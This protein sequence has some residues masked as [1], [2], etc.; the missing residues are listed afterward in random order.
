MSCAEISGSFPRLQAHKGTSP[1]KTLILDE[2]NIYA[3]GL[4]AILATPK[5]LKELT[6]GENVDNVDPPSVTLGSTMISIT[7]AIEALS[8]TAHSLEKLTHLNRDHRRFVGIADFL[9][10]QRPLLPGPGFKA[11]DALKYVECDK[12][13]F[14]H[15]YITQDP[16]FAPPNLE[17]YRLRSHKYEQEII[18]SMQHPPDFYPFA[19]LQNLKCIEVLKPVRVDSIL[20][21]CNKIWRPD[22]ARSL[23]AWAYKLWKHG[24]TTKLIIQ[25]HLDSPFPPYLFGERTPVVFQVYDSDVIGFVRPVTD[26]MQVDGDEDDDF[27][28]SWD[29]SSI[30]SNESVSDVE[31][32]ETPLLSMRDIQMLYLNTRHGGMNA[33]SRQAHS[34]YDSDSTESDSSDGESTNSDS[35]S[36]ESDELMLDGE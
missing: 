14:V 29:D 33:L 17:V 34:Y 10:S 35:D 9:P 8:L 16:A 19:R 27:D 21:I 13:S 36:D 30:E 1:L 15:R 2:C 24:I 4:S 22:R 11:F 32:R 26:D 18:E 12:Y 3:G 31:P 6:L 5:A 28:D 23:H 25:A 20:E 7:G